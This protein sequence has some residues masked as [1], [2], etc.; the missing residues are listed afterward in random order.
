MGQV[1]KRPAARSDLVEIWSFIA[2]DNQ[3]AADRFLN[4]LETKLKTLSTQPQ[5]GRTR[6]ELMAGLRS[7]PVASYVVFYLPMSD[8]IDIVRVLHSARDIDMD[9]FEASGNA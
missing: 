8:G 3:V 2:D 7:F 9:D 6:P 5:M 4:T 1:F